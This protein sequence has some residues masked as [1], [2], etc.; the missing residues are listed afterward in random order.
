MGVGL[1]FIASVCVLVA[2]LVYIVDATGRNRNPFLT[3]HQVEE[4]LNPLYIV[5]AKL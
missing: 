3:I 5:L 4:Y 1:S 2:F